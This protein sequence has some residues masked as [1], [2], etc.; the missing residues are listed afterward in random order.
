MKMKFVK[1]TAIALALVFSGVKA[2]NLAPASKKIIKAPA[3]EKTARKTAA[4]DK[5]EYD[6]AQ[7]AIREDYY[8]DLNQL[9]K[10]AVA[11]DYV[12]SLR[13]HADSIG[14]YVANWK[15]SDKRA[16]A[17]KDYLITQGVAANRIVTTPYGS[18]IPIASNQTPEGRQR[19]RRVEIKL[20]KIN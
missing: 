9:A 16:L 18:T 19:N 4:V 20:Q 11:E 6:F 1:T 15:L 7:S 17:V 10:T 12:L 14:N 2:Y 13:G 3:E 8:T 5:L